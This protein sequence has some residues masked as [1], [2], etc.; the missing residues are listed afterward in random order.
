MKHAFFTLTMVWLLINQ[1]SAQ[2]FFGKYTLLID[3]WKFRLETENED[4]LLKKTDYS[5]WR[6]VTLPHDW[7]VEGPYS[8]DKAYFRQQVAEKH[9]LIFC[10]LP[11][12]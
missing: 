9:W 8:P 10:L 12:L 3:H 4:N 11:N 7:S 2:P 1:I 5:N 6:D